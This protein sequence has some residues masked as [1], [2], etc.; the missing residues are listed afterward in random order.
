MKE[1]I[2]RVLKML[3]EGKIDAE[4]AA[5]F[6]D[7]LKSNDKSAAAKEVSPEYLNKMLKVNISEQ[8]GDKVNVKVPIKFI[9]ALGGAVTKIPGVEMQGVDIKV[10]MDAIDEGLDGKIVDI[11]SENGDIV[12]IVIE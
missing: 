11:S 6:I 3:E 8:G 1:E 5:E 9:K 10:I 7:L 4:K 12:E 2:Q